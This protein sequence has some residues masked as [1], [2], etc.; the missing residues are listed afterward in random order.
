MIDLNYEE[1]FDDGN[2]IRFYQLRH[3]S[4]RHRIAMD[5]LS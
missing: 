2:D 3:I 4:L 1:Y 5:D